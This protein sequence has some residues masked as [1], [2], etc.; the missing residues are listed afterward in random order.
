MRTVMD[1]TKLR[2]TAPNFSAFG[3]FPFITMPAESR[4]GVR[5]RVVFLKRRA[6]YP[7]SLG[8]IAAAFTRTSASSPPGTGIATSSIRKTDGG[9]NSLNH[10]DFIKVILRLLQSKF[11]ARQSQ[12][13]CTTSDRNHVRRSV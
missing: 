4:P 7:M 8:L 3:V 1:D 9:P 13:S 12:R 6:T 11:D 5:G 2:R 10:N